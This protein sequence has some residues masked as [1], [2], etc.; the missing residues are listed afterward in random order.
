M[1]ALARHITVRGLV[2]GVAFRHHTKL[3]ARELGLLGWVRNQ[4][5]GSVEI[6][7]EGEP[8]A[9]AN[10]IDWL[11]V[12]PPAARVDRVEVQVAQ[13]GSPTLDAAQRGHFVV[14]REPS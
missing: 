12:G 8:T 10:L 13:P 9:I 14:L 6:W 2:Q 4:T 1:A 3:R 7:A 5:D 11:H